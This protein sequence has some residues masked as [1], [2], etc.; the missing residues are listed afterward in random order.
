ML[1]DPEYT[2]WS[3]KRISLL[4]IAQ[5]DLGPAQPPVQ[6]VSEVNQPACEAD[7]PTPSGTKVKSECS[8]TSNP[9]HRVTTSRGTT[10]CTHPT[11]SF[12]LVI[13]IT[14][15]NR[16]NIGKGWWTRFI[17]MS[18]QSSFARGPDCQVAVSGEWEYETSAVTCHERHLNCTVQHCARTPPT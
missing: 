3:Y 11:E 9:P 4:Q 5:T 7:H 16:P 10:S 17:E 14:G 12:C 15:L 8:C 18:Y 6:W 2:S 13:S 1:D